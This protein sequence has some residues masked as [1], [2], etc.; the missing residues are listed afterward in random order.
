[1]IQITNQ[2]YTP[3]V[4]SKWERTEDGFL[5]C[6]ARVLREGIMPYRRE[7][8][9][10]PLPD[11][12]KIDPVM[13]LV[14]MDSMSSADSLRSLEGAA[15]VV[16]AHEWVTPDNFRSVAHGHVAG[17][18]RVEGP[19]LEVDLVVTDPSA[20]QRIEAGELPEVSAAYHAATV[21]DPGE[22][23]GNRYDAKQVQL[24][25]NHIAV[26]PAGEGR[27]G[28]DVKILNEKGAR[29]MSVR[30][31]LPLT[32][33]FINT[34]EEGGSAV[35]AENASAAE[36]QS[37]VEGTM[38]QLESK[39][40]DMQSLQEEI[41]ALK[42]ELNQYKTKLDELLSDEAVEAKAMDMMAEQT[43]ADEIIENA[44]P[45]EE[46]KEEFKNTMKS[47]HGVKLMNSVLAL[48]GVDTEGM[49]EEALRGAFRAQKQISKLMRKSATV[50]GAKMTGSMMAQNTA[51]AR[52]ERT[53]LQK[54]GY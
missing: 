5:R 53:H 34:D 29:Q 44:C 50:A 46:K 52:T 37:G 31:K 41:D 40:K 12:I 32:G 38:S 16:G 22:W 6:R 27:A 26:I 49:S 36:V 9:E 42:A 11:E 30:V 3:G 1:V 15:V 10:Q 2:H 51:G 20:I 18:P 13:M 21:F 17:A 45:D 48:I 7:E 28:T 19:F 24:R 25:Y 35:E 4:P 47:L 33:R 39:T 23:D 8:F 14:N 54:L 43:D